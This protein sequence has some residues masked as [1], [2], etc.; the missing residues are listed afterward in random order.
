MDGQ[1]IYAQDFL[2]HP[3]FLRNERRNLSDWARQGTSVQSQEP[4]HWASD[5]LNRNKIQVE[6][7]SDYTQLKHV[8]ESVCNRWKFLQ[9]SA[10]KRT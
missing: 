6:I 10:Q 9:K 5:I 2:G 8:T 7:L 4:V 1:Q 3:A